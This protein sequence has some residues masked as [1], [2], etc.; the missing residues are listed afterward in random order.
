VL[1]QHAGRHRRA[2]PVIEHAMHGRGLADAGGQSRSQRS[3]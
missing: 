1:T 3:F 2:R